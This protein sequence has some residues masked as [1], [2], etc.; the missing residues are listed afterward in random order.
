MK[1]G[2]DLDNTIVDY[3]DAVQI[4]VKDLEIHNVKTIPELRNWFR[5][6][7]RNEEWTRAQSWLY[8][9]GLQFAKITEGAFD[10]LSALN[11]FP[12]EFSILS[13]KSVFGPQKYGSREFRKAMNDWFS[14]SELGNMCINKIEYF[15]S[16][17]EKIEGIRRGG[18]A[19][20]IDDLRKVFEHK[21]FPHV[22]F[23]ILFST[24][25]CRVQNGESGD[26]LTIEKFS[27]LMDLLSSR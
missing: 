16:L 6:R 13:H 19:Y 24:E 23:P 4:Y 14:G 11:K 5:I 15:N 26:I 17:D 1:I 22:T 18:F 3:S 7:N 8:S 10:V 12:F 2:F 9:E 27:S 21:N 20:F 25:K